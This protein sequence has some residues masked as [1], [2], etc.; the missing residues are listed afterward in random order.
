M[1]DIMK[2]ILALALVIVM[3]CVALVSC[4]GNSA[5]TLA[6]GGTGGTYY[7]A[8]VGLAGLF[9]SLPCKK[10]PQVKFAL[11]AILAGT[12][13]FICHTLSGTLAFEAY[14]KGQNALAYS[15]VY[16]LYV[17]VDAGL[18]VLVGIILFSARSFIKTVEK[19]ELK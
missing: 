10:L 5:Y 8:C 14:A 17:F 16:N 7:A 3:L 11:G 1:E 2:K 13:R 9:K 4:G 18:I 19:A 15:L 12:L 6:S